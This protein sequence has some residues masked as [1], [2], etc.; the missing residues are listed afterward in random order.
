MPLSLLLV[1]Y[2]IA[3]GMLS[4]KLVGHLLARWALGE[5]EYRRL[6]Q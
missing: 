3:L 6:S 1:P 2:A 4:G 5:A